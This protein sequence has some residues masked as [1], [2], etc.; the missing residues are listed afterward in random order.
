MFRRKKKIWKLQRPLM[1]NMP[2]VEAMAYTK[3][4][5]RICFVAMTEDEMEELFGE[6]AKAY[7]WGYINKRGVL[8]ID[9]DKHA[10][11]QDW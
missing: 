7:V 3:E 1:G 4:Q 9:I 8:E 6:N 10:D 2:V 11:W 5:D